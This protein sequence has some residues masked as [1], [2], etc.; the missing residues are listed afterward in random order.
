MQQAMRKDLDSTQRFDAQIYFTHV[1]CFISPLQMFIWRKMT[2]YTNKLF[3]KANQ[4]PKTHLKLAA[5]LFGTGEV[6]VDRSVSVI[7]QEFHMAH[8]TQQP[9][10]ICNHCSVIRRQK[11]N[12][13]LTQ[14]D[15]N[16]YIN[17]L[18]NNKVFS[19]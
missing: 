11:Q 13:Y 16:P 7:Q 14:H 15:T 18:I 1:Q 4:Y 17:N 2:R 6:L 19:S 10:L 12:S 3:I 5:L 8:K 9:Y